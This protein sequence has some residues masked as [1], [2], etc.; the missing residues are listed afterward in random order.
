[1]RAKEQGQLEQVVGV[2]AVP[3]GEAGELVEDADGASVRG[4]RY[5]D[6]VHR[7]SFSGE[8]NGGDGVVMEKL[9]D[10]LGEA[11]EQGRGGGEWEEQ[12]QQ[13]GAVDKQCSRSAPTQ[14]GGVPGRRGWWSR[15]RARGPGSG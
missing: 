5:P 2:G 11:G 15:C 6:L 12:R 10:G 9:G 7:A 1:M 8:D 14:S 4:G 13:R 3:V